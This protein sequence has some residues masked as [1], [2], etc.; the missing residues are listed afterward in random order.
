LALLDASRKCRIQ[1][2]AGSLLYYARAVDNKLLVAFSAISARKAK[3][4]FTTEQ[5]ADLLLDYIATSPSDGIV[6]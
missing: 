6:Y 3:A 1:E 2:I 4:T 5:A